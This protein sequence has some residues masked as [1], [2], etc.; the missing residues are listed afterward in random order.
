MKA[1]PSVKAPPSVKTSFQQIQQNLLTEIK[2][3]QGENSPL[4]HQKI[5][6]EENIKSKEESYYLFKENENTLQ[7][8]I[9]SQ[10]NTISK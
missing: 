1:S 9:I 4:K 3:L 10:E 6:L 2:S 8:Q 5:S 7:I